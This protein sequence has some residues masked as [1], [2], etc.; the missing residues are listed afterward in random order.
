MQ[1]I[2][3]PAAYDTSRTAGAWWEETVASPLN[4][5]TLNGDL[6]TD[7]A[8]VGAGYTGLNAALQLAEAHGVRAVVLDA[9]Q[10]AW[11]ASGRNGGF[12]CIGGAKLPVSA[13]IKR[14]GLEE[15]QKFHASQLAAIQTVRE[16]L[17]RYQIDADTHSEDGELCLAHRASTFQ[18]MRDEVEFEAK[19]FDQKSELIP[20]GALAERGMN[21][22]GAHGALLS[23]A[24]FALNPLKYAQGLAHAAQNLGIPIYSNSPVTKITQN[25]SRLSLHHPRGVVNARKVIIAT[26]GYSSDDIPRELAGRFLPVISSILVTR[27][28][29]PI[30]QRAQGWTSDLMSYDSRNLLHYFRLMPDGRFL[31]GQRGARKADAAHTAANKRQNRLDFERMFP[32]WRGVESTH[33]WSGL[34]CTT[35]NRHPYIGPLEGQSQIFAALGFHGNGVSLASYS[36]RKLADLVAGAKPDLPAAL[37]TPLWRFALPGLRRHYLRLAFAHYRLKDGLF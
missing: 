1:R 35:L 6:T 13:Q 18:A 24:G 19:L 5:P 27:P 33:Y 20:K 7:V 29:T 3:E 17:E 28:I 21:A 12:A 31:F 25:A 9:A 11:G 34:I 14:F 37:R 10:P 8:I 16:N 32:A 4:F 22:T 15:T 2:Y 30:E 36:G 23:K 26:N